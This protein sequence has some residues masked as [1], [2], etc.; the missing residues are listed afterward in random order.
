MC[1]YAETEAGIVVYYHKLKTSRRLQSFRYDSECGPALQPN[2]M[3][4]GCCSRE[5]RCI[6]R[7]A[8]L[9]YHLEGRCF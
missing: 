8:L 9:P 4:L 5:E 1:L 3:G 7:G 6:M 2:E